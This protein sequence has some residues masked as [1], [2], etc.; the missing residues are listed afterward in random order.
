V[1]VGV[2]E[3]STAN[4]APD[5]SSSGV[6]DA[7]ATGERAPAWHLLVAL[8]VVG[9]LA[10]GLV[11]VLTRN[12]PA[13]A[14]PDSQAYLATADQLRHGH[15]YTVPFDTVFD[16]RTPAGVAGSGGRVPLAHWSPALPTAIAALTPVFGTGL[17]AARF[18]N[19]GLLVA[20]V[21][22]AGWIVF[23]I[24]RSRWRAVVVAAVFGFLPMTLSMYRLVLAD[25]MLITLMLAVVLATHVVVER[26]TPARLALLTLLALA[27]AT[28][29]HAGVAVAVAAALTVA[30]LTAGSLWARLTRLAVVAVPAVVFEVLWLQRGDARS[31]HV[32]PP[33]DV[34]VR[35]LAQW[36]GGWFGT[37]AP[38]GLRPLAIVLA[39]ALFAIAAWSAFG[40]DLPPARRA[41][42]ISLGLSAVGVAF[43]VVL[44]RTF[45]EAPV[46]FNGRNLY[47]VQAAV[48]LLVGSVRVGVPASRPVVVWSVAGVG[49]AVALLA[50]WP[51]ASRDAWQYSFAGPTSTVHWVTDPIPSRRTWPVSPVAARLPHDASLVSDYPENL[52]FDVGRGAIQLP[53]KRDIV[54]DTDD[55]EFAAHLREVGRLPAPRYL[56]LY[57]CR[58]N[59]ALFPTVDEIRAE[60]PITRVYRD[61]TS[62]IFRVR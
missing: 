27:A 25:A 62:C 21:V 40:H 50:V 9:A 58:G 22:L 23:R 16:A 57:D 33:G 24:T 5:A 10:A 15:G 14:P 12:N 30:L 41:L 19:A 51:W 46:A 7:P 29:K 32:H 4:A 8:L 55:D 42:T 49:A 44:T 61:D 53:P 52:W 59:G 17:E 18:W 45:V 60:V 11:L 13:M 2:R 20:A 3:E 36:T 56:V 28:T 1:R 39:V 38:S 48:L 37:G 26:V 47:A 54:A 31:L 6:T 34:D 35:A 43:V